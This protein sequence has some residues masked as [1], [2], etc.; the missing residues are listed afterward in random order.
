MF[1]HLVLYTR[2]V[3][4]N[5][6]PKLF[7]GLTLYLFGQSPSR[8]T[9]VDIDLSALSHDCLLDGVCRLLQASHQRFII[10]NRLELQ[11]DIFIY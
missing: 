11:R 9:P 4:F 2:M 3:S 10:D 6:C 1:I 5:S 8:T 7:P